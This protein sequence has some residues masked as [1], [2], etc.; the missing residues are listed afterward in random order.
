M[1]LL[2]GDIKEILRAKKAKSS[3]GK[4]KAILDQCCLAISESLFC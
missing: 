1:Y 2:D 3:K 4:G